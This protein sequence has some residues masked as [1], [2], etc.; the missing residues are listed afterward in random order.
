MT[1]QDRILAEKE[2][3][4]FIK[5]Y[6]QLITNHLTEIRELMTE[7]TSQIMDGVSKISDTKDLKKAMAEAVLV[8]RDGSD[9]GTVE[10][11]GDS[12]DFKNVSFKNIENGKS[13]HPMSVGLSGHLKSF[14]GLDNRIQDILFAMIGALS[15]DDVVSQRLEHIG[16]AF[17]ALNKGVETSLPWLSGEVDL[18]RVKVFENQILKSV[19]DSYTM[20]EEH[21]VLERVFNRKIREPKKVS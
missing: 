11:Q 14:E 4:D 7:T 21:E 8:K 12:E 20:E 19:S 10:I 15:A 16:D 1:S 9:G 3:I 17:M 6:S 18:E 13:E 5:N 2:F